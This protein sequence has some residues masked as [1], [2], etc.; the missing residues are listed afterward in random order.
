MVA[1]IRH[2]FKENPPKFKGPRLCE[3]TQ[4]FNNEVKKIFEA[5]QVTGS[6]VVKLASYQLKDLNHTWFTEFKNN[7]DYFVRCSSI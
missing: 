7:I 4:K 5:I 2:L 1:S 3:E 6:D